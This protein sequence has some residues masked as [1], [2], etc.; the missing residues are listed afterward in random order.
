MKTPLAWVNLHVPAILTGAGLGAG[1]G[2]EA[3]LGARAG[4]EEALGAEEQAPT[5]KA[6]NDTNTNRTENHFVFIKI[7]LCGVKVPPNYFKV[8]YETLFHENIISCCPRHMVLLPEIR[9]SLLF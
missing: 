8:L 7:F 9:I 1:T 3:E 6:K 5:T 2:I 4:F